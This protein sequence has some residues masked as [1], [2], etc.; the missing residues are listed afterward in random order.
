LDFSIYSGQADH[1]IE[2]RS[3]DTHTGGKRSIGLQLDT[4]LAFDRLQEEAR[5]EGIE[6]LIA[7]GFRDFDRQLTIWNAKARG[8]RPVLNDAGTLIDAESLSPLELAH[9]IMRWSALPGAS[10]HHWG[11]DLDVYD[12]ATLSRDYAL[13]LVPEEYE[14]RGPFANL[15]HW[16][17][18]R[19]KRNE[20]FGFFLPYAKDSG[21]IAPEPWH[22][23]YAPLAAGYQQRWGVP[24]LRECLASADILL[25]DD[26]VPEL[27]A[28]FS[29]YVN[30]DP[31]IYP[32]PFQ[33]PSV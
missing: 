8:D 28:I 26:L 14:A 15:A 10:R 4:W 13:Q 29:R 16:L 6:L 18:D 7:S 12:G 22:L 17:S 27:D 25:A 30:V 20:A 2:Y 9:A 24:G 5:E 31:T 33:W 3:V 1:H 19:V 21:G 32:E 11:T 23:S